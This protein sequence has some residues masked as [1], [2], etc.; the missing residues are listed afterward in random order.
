MIRTSQAAKAALSALSIAGLLAVSG[1]SALAAATVTNP[2]SANVSADSVTGSSV[3]LPA[4]TITEGAAG[5]IAAG[6]LTLALP[7]GFVFDT[8]SVA[9][10]A[11][12]GAGL[13]GSST[14]AFL[15]SAHA[16][17]TVTS[18]STAAG[19]LTVGSTT[20]LKVKASS[21]T[22]P[23][24]GIITLSAGTIAGLTATS[25]LGTLTEIPGA[26][27]KL[28]FTVQPAATATVNTAFTPVTVSVEDQFGNVITSDSGRTITLSAAN[29]SSTLGGTTSMNDLN[30]AATFSDLTYPVA[31][32]LQLSA[33][34][35]PL[36][37]ATSDLITVSASSTPVPTTTPPTVSCG[38]QNGQ[39][40]M[41]QGSPTVYMAV[42]CVLRPFTSAAIFHA[43]GRKFSEVHD[44]LASLFDQLGIGRPVGESSDD[45]STIITPPAA[46]STPSST[47]PSI[48]GLP[49]GAVVKLPNDP[50]VYL[51]SGGQLQPFTSAAIFNLRG[52]HFGNVQTISQQ[53][54]SQM[55]VGSPVMPPNGTVVRGSGQTV[56]VIQNG[57]AV[58]IPTPQAL[59][60]LGKTFRDIVK[61]DDG[62]LNRMP[63]GD[64]GN[65]G[66]DNGN[67][68]QNRDN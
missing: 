57:Q 34:S 61:I 64:H 3:S 23:A 24:S 39:L 38:L 29:A 6:T 55:S 40:V 2:V 68:G 4:L 46:S 8:G 28:A 18:T 25:S 33:S 13:A 11:F 63:R 47:L 16:Q 43:R 27:N 5:D 19:S 12:S 60:Q 10:V 59:T 51:V 22:L 7:A 9:N 66:G 48:S 42:N 17:V 45:D 58:G 41:V 15:D 52:E 50:T 31:G 44:I 36:T 62:T 37:S 53:Q 56:Y 67:N 21:G 1:G 26:A 14:V 35:S 49:D 20:P 30:G 32:T 54:F 65:N